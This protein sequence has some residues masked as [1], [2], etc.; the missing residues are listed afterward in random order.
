MLITLL[1]E[2]YI[3]SRQRRDKAQGVHYVEE[4]HIT[5]VEDNALYSMKTLSGHLGLK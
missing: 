5:L 3:K 4:N 2:K 1:G